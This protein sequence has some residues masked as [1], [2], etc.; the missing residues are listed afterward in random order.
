MIEDEKTY[1]N[2]SIEDYIDKIKDY[3]VLKKEEEVELF[4]K[5]KNGNEDAKNKLILSNLKLVVSVAKKYIDKGV[6]FQDLIQ[7]GN[8]GLFKAIEKFDNK[9]DLKFST[10]AY[11]WIKKYVLKAIDKNCRIQ[12]IDAKIKE[13]LKDYIEGEI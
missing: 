3:K 13:S 12:E 9:R 2:N 11:V 5:Y 6:P 10:Y 7:E 8:L 4:D 1:Y